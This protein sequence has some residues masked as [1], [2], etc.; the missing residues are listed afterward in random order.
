MKKTAL[1]N[2]HLA[3]KAKLIPFTGYEMPL[4]YSGIVQEHLA[5]RS[6]AGL[7]DV[8]HMGEFIIRGPEA[9]KFLQYTTVNDVS[10]LID[11]QAQ[12][13]ALCYYDGGIVDDLL[14]YRFSDHFMLVV[15]AS[16]IE[17]DFKWLENNLIPG[18]T[19]ENRSDEISLIAIQGPKSRAILSQLTAIDLADLPFYHFLEG[20]VAGQ[21][22][23]VA[24]TG[25]TGELG[26]EI[27]GFNADIPSIWD[28]LVQVGAG[29]GL[30]PVGLGAR[31]TLRLEMKYCLYG[32]DIDATTNPI[33]AG[34]GWITKLDKGDFI[35]RA[36]ILEK[37]PNLNRR[38][39]CLEMQERAVPRPGY[40]IYK[41]DDEIGF[42][43]SGTQSPVLR[44]G[45]GLA[46]IQRGFTKLNTEVMVLIRGEK[47]KALIV[48]PPFY[49]HGT[50]QD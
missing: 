26:Y 37:K 6:D 17:N 16:N 32:N 48:K 35:G 39:V 8:S 41:A 46:Y 34:L 18:V 13:S 33:E 11:G 50:A 43:T 36:A 27:Y 14:I 2:Q 24:R 49:K 21:T 42:I 25:Y 20:T 5:V 10:A 4:H 30:I 1:Y 22:V 45:I 15:N 19:L 28:E 31:D 44:K 23:T 38:L 12:Y 29:S 3:L 40:K 9:E 47:K 7:F